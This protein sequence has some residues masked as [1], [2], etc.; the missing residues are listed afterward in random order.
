MSIQTRSDQEIQPQFINREL[1]WLEFNARV[2][3]QALRDD[4]PPLERLKFLCIVTSNFDEFFMVRVASV[5]R[6][7]RDGDYVQCPSGVPPSV[8]LKQIIARTRELI[9]RKY[10]CLLEDVLPRLAAHGIVLRRPGGYTSA[11]SSFLKKLFQEEIFPVLT[12]IRATV[13]KEVPYVTN[14]RLNAAFILEPQQDVN[15]VSENEDAQSEFLAIVQIPTSLER[16]IYLPD[17]ADTVSFALL[18]DVIVQHAAAL[19]PGYRVTENCLFRVTR[20]ADMGVD[21]ERDEDF[22]EAMEQVLQ[23]R[24]FS[25]PVRLSV[26]QGAG[27]LK[28]V[29]SQVVGIDEGEVFDKSEPLDLGEFMKLT[30]IPGFD[31]LRFPRWHHFDSADVPDE[32]PIWD[33]IKRRDILLHHP[34]ESFEP[35]VRLL[36]DAAA[37]PGVLAIKMTLYRTSGDSPVVRALEQAAEAGKQVTVLVEI[38]ARFDEERNITWAQRLERAGVQGELGPKL[39]EQRDPQYWLD[40]EG[41]PKPKLANEDPEPVTVTYEELIESWNE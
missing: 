21:E 40:Q 33:T 17:G 35:V 15:L 29:L 11:Q 22:V 1:S 24:D 31:E 3:H 10:Q 7:I 37:D 38:K 27:R 8:L 34:F 13:G 39:N 28:G 20:D 5:K 4:V 18:E 41:S 36:Q 14:L 19:F 12:P 30:T 16:I 2:L 32:G 23:R 25:E 26:T 6:Q 9:D